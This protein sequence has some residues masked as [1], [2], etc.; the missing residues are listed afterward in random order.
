M[1]IVGL[2]LALDVLRADGRPDWAATVLGAVV[3]A[4]VASEV[5]AL[6]LPAGGEPR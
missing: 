5:T 3:I 2:A 4:T 1:G 6:V